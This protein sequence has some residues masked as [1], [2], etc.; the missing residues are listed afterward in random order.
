MSFQKI[1]QVVFLNGASSSGKS[2][3]A[4]ALQ[5]K[6]PQ[7]FL[8][9]G[10]DSVIAMMPEKLNDWQGGKVDS[11]FWWNVHVDDDGHQL[12][13]IQMGEY[14]QKISDL[15]KPLMLTMLEHGHNVIVDEVCTPKGWLDEWRQVLREYQVV[16][17]GMKASVSTLEMRENL[18]GNRMIG[19]AR[20]QNMTVHE[21]NT[22]DL[23]LD[24]DLYSI[25]ECV[26]QVKQV[27]YKA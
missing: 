10:I 14:A 18:R 19:A 3:L 23:E 17:V 12:A 4:K 15:L 25:D 11:G 16:Y 6:L 9:V 1:P 27:L 26:E 7:P 8:H 2:T 21:G 13:Y 5:L 24:V 20:A 22:Y